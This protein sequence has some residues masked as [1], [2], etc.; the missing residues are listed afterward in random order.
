MLSHAQSTRYAQ[1]VKF[2]GMILDITGSIIIAVSLVNLNSHVQKMQAAGDEPV[3]MDLQKSAIA[4]LQDQS[5]QTVTG[6]IL[7]VVGFVLLFG[8][9]FFLFVRG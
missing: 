5:G 7:V 3:P 9:E 8:E 1:Y 2:I 6:I 4:N